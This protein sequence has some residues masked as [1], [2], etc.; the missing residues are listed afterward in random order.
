M[1]YRVIMLPILLLPLGG[2]LMVYHAETAIPP[3]RAITDARLPGTWGDAREL[4][5]PQG[6]AGIR[7]EAGPG[8]DYTVTTSLDVGPPQTLFARLGQL[9][10]H[11]VVEVWPDPSESVDAWLAGTRLL[12]V[13]DLKDDELTLRHLD[14]SRLATLLEE[15]GAN[16]SF[17]RRGSDLV[18]TSPTARLSTF[19]SEFL[20]RP[21]ALGDPGESMHL[22]RLRDRDR[23]MLP[24]GSGRPPRGSP[25]DLPRSG[26]NPHEAADVPWHNTG[27]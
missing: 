12:L 8:T 26:G 9:G 17:E 11:T 4:D 21:D 15:Q 1:H 23:S 13:V 14:G 20:A 3:D 24:T 6:D 16:L 27:P 2:C 22:I 19:Y 25:F 10:A 5:P 18:I 7:I